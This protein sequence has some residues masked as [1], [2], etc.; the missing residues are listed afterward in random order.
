MSEQTAVTKPDEKVMSA[1]EFFDAPLRMFTTLDLDTEE[2]KAAA[3]ALTMSGTSTPLAD[4]ANT[5]I[6]VE[7][8]LVHGVT[9]ADKDGVEVYADRIVLISP[10]G[11]AYSCVSVGVRKSLQMLIAM[12]KL[13]PWKPARQLKL[14]PSRTRK[15]FTT[16]NLV[17]VVGA[18]VVSATP[19]SNGSKAKNK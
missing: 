18:Q 8:I 19:E 4:N 6:E 17:P 2:G 9:L 15:G 7:N 1:Q 13:P 12:Y 14:V 10:T 5:V 3:I 16:F 11:Q